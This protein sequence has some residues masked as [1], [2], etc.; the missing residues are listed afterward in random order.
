VLET[1]GVDLLPVAEALVEGVRRVLVVGQRELGV[2]ETPVSLFQDFYFF[3]FEYKNKVVAACQ[4]GDAMT[5]RYAAAQLQQEIS[6]MLNKVDAGFFGE[7]FNLLGEYAAGYATAGFPD[8]LRVAAQGDLVALAAR[9]QRLD[10][11]MQ[12]WLEV[13]GVDLNI[14]A[15]EATLARFLGERQGK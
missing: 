13:Q 12:A 8:L 9:V 10:S 6:T 1:A 4:R 5:A 7:P 14:L 15:D 11:Q 3:V 2:G